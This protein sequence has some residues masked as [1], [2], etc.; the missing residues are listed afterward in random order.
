MV[1]RKQTIRIDD[2]PAGDR[3]RER[4][5]AEGVK[6]LTNGE[7]MAILLNSGSTEVSAIDLGN[8]LL[9]DLGGF[10]GIHR[11]DLSRLMEFKGIGLAKA[12]RIKAAIEIGYRMSKESEEDAIFIKTPENIVDL[13]GF[14]MKGLSQEQLWVLLLNSRNRYLGKERLYKG[15]QDA[16]TVRVAEIF[17]DAVRKNVYAIALV[18]NHPSGNPGESPEDVNLT[19]AVTEAGKILDIRLIDHVI[20]AANDYSSIRRNHPELWA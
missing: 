10:S 5:L 16:T 6:A 4:M 13:V 19:R 12:T 3:P 8:R 1:E 2:L 17:K 20:I 11:E 9:N 14:E 15:S 18:H 7:L